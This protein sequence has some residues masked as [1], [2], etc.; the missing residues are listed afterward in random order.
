MLMMKMNKMCN[1]HKKN[2]LSLG[3]E[4]FSGRG[5]F[6]RWGRYQS[7]LQGAGAWGE[8]GCRAELWGGSG[9][10]FKEEQEMKSD[11]EK[12]AGD[13]PFVVFCDILFESPQIFDKSLN[14]SLSSSN[15]GENQHFPAK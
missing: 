7:R 2:I 13:G 9:C 10:S 3:S 12:V 4:S 6:P 11:K 15:S 8:G 14:S 1:W 5:S